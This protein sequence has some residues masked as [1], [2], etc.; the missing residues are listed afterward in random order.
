[1][2]ALLKVASELI[3]YFVF[4]GSSGYLTAAMAGLLPLP[5]LNSLVLSMTAMTNTGTMEMLQ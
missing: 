3:C 1:M 4:S 5:L 2:K